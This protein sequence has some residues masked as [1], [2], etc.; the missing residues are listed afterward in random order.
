MRPT[1]RIS[2]LLRRSVGPAI[3]LAA[4]ASQQAHS[5]PDSQ[6]SALADRAAAA[7]H[8]QFALL[9]AP[10]A[11]PVPSCQD[12]AA[13][14]SWLAA[15]AAQ[16]DFDACLELASKCAAALPAGT[17]KLDG[18]LTA[19][20]ACAE[21]LDRLDDAYRLYERAT[22]PAYAASPGFA[23][24]VYAFAGFARFTDHASETARILAKVPAWRAPDQLSLVTDALDYLATGEARKHPA[25]ELDAWILAG[26]AGNDPVLR[27]ALVRGWAAHLLNH[28]YLYSDAV[29]YL[30]GHLDEFSNPHGW[31][32]LAYGAFYDQA[33]QDSV[34]AR[35]IYDAYRPYAHRRSALPQEDNTYTY[36]EL[37]ASACRDHLLQ[38][39]DR[40]EFSRLSH[41]WSYGLIRS[42][43]ALAR[44]LKIQSAHPNAADAA[45]LVG[46][47]QDMLGQ[48]APAEA[49]FWRAHLLCPYYDRAHWGLS[50]LHYRQR[51]RAYADYALS[52]ARIDRETAG[53]A[54]PPVLSKYVINWD[55]LGD[56]AQ[57]RLKYATR[58]WAPFVAG[59]Y[60]S[61]ARIF[62]KPGAI[63]LSEAPGNENLRD[64]RITYDHDNRNWD[65]VRGAGGKTVVVDYEQMMSAAFGD[66]NLA[67]HEITHQFQGG[68][69]KDSQLPQAQFDC[70]VRLY[71]A[72]KARG[73]F[74]DPYSGRNFLEYLAQ[75]VA[76]FMTPEDSSARLGIN[77]SWLKAHDPDMLGFLQDLQL[78]SPDL[79]AI[80]C[81]VG[82]DRLME[83][84]AAADG[85]S[86][87]IQ[88]HH[89][90][91]ERRGWNDSQ[92]AL[93]PTGAWL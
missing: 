88:L 62:V 8:S 33:T 46:G 9:L 67:G 30:V 65:D 66:Y 80:R 81:P 40:I 52:L 43:Q 70:S 63:L 71:E 75:G 85:I 79:S 4:I 72:A 22:S 13:V 73:V 14:S 84:D 82:A 16:G 37:Y 7:I 42:D 35:R 6:L 60:R 49:S 2:C 39:A 91:S 74:A 20:G 55:F 38:G 57:K 24:R 78:H 27:P 76:Y 47:I 59:L 92:D 1:S 28:K 61:G 48:E 18:V 87:L 56:E 51:A 32:S 34:L 5:D 11:R 36:G 64:V 31:A 93:M 86:P 19:G 15:I 89:P 29:H 53:L 83:S 77:V 26:A 12:P 58:F 90:R 68:A 41:D 23:G 3:V 50:R 69:A 17:P 10:L 44:A 21:S 54:F 25:A 45:N